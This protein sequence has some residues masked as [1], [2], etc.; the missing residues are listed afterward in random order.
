VQTYVAANYPLQA[1]ARLVEISC[2]VVKQDFILII[3]VVFGFEI[4]DVAEVTSFA[5]F[6]IQNSDLA[7]TNSTKMR[8]KL[9][10][11]PT[12]V[13]CLIRHLAHDEEE[14]ELLHFFIPRQYRSR[15]VHNDHINKVKSILIVWIVESR[16]LMVIDMIVQVGL[17]T[18]HDLV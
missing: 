16:I 4:L 10:T 2:S 5:I 1:F 14:A 12:T 17:V 3:L 15:P 18:N 7:V 6:A 9:N 11:E 13:N 8:Q